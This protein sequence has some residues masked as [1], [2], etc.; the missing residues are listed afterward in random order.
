MEGLSERGTLNL[1]AIMSQVPK[2]ILEGSKCSIVDGRGI[3]LSMAENWLIRNEV[4][5]ISKAAIQNTFEAHVRFITG[6]LF[7]KDFPRRL[8][9]PA[10]QLANRLLGRPGSFGGPC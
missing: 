10:S 7:V 9:F 8:T 3:D 5:D 4:L 1:T 2:A 6:L